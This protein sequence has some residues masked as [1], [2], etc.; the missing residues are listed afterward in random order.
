MVS[1]AFQQTDA[2]RAKSR[3]PRQKN[4]CTVR[5]LALAR[6]LHYDAAYDDLKKAGRGCSERFDMARWLNGQEWAKKLPFP[7]V[8]GQPRMNPAEFCRRYLSG[9]YI[10]RSAKHV[11][12]VIDGVVM[13]DS[14]VRADRCIYTAWHI[15]RDEA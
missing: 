7:A 14:P 1:V 9:T 11:F 6:S 2:G 5:A 12:A 4:D 10:C 8:K 3:R 13:D 15:E